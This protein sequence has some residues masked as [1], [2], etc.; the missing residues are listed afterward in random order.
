MSEVKVMEMPFGTIQFRTWDAYDLTV[1]AELDKF[2]LDSEATKQGMY[3]EKWLGVLH[4]AQTI[5]AAKQE[6]LDNVKAELLLEV[7]RNGVQGVVKMTE[8]TADAWITLHP[9]Y[10]SALEDKSIAASN[11]QYLQNAIK[12]LEHKRDMIKT[13]DHLWVAGYYARPNVSPEAGKQSQ[14]KVNEVTKQDLSNSLR[15]R[16]LI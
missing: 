4:Q 3:M 15:R 14:E 7:K 1:D 9:K 2:D 5:L 12:V 16:K 13:L 8:A 11:V 10:K 6:A